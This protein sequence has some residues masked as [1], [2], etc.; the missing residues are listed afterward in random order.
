M[1]KF[2]IKFLNKIFLIVKL[3]VIHKLKIFLRISKNKKY[4]GVPQIQIQFRKIKN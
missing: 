3:T 1:I 2:N 4:L